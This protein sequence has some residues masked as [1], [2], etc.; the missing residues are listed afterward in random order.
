MPGRVGFEF[1]FTQQRKREAMNPDEE[2]PMRILVMGDLSGRGNRGVADAA[3]LAKR[4]MVPV[5]VDNFDKVLSRFAPRLHLPLGNAAGS[6]MSIDF[7]ELNDFHPDRLFRDLGV[8]AA[9]RQTRALLKDPATFAAAAATL[10]QSAAPAAETDKPPAAATNS[11]A[12]EDAAGMFERLLG[13]KPEAAGAAPKQAPGQ[14]PGNSA[15]ID[16]L[17]RQIVAP[18][19]VPDAS[20]LQAPYVASVEAAIGEQMRLLLHHPEFQALESAWRAI[21]WLIAELEIGEQLKLYLLDVTQ[22]ELRADMH[23]ADGN[24]ERSGFYRL[25][26]RHG[27]APDA[28]PWSLLVGNYS[29]TAQDDDIDLLAWHGAIASQAGGP[30]LAAAAASVLGCGSLVDTPDARDW[31]AIDANAAERWQ[32]LR[33]SAVA[34]W[35]G[36]AMP[37]MLLRLPYGK[38]SDALDQFDF[39]EFTAVRDHEAY[40]WGNPAMACALL[41]G[42][43]FLERGWEMEPGDERD[44]GDLPAHIYEHDGE[45]R[46]QACAETYLSER[47]GE[48]MLARGLMPLLS[49]ANHNA[50]RLLRFQSL[51]QPAQALAGPWR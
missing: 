8:F 48:A 21:R 42:R 10:Q 50:A 17:I 4:A 44:V 5:D 20:P 6:P 37:R 36:L 41:I 7:H 29:F 22:D 30:F 35:L 38:H 49:L 23:A 11:G 32:A 31:P 1:Q 45:K 43:A 18:H 9:L 24:P 40:L 51:A 39:E 26:T 19:I 34:A 12:G 46:M 14:S 2:S 47:T 25:L 27:E 16:A 15:G 13:R 28:E 3:D 33:Q